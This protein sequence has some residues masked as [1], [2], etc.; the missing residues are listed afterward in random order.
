MDPRGSEMPETCRPP[1]V[2]ASSHA[3]VSVCGEGEGGT[4]CALVWGISWLLGAEPGGGRGNT[5]GPQLISFR[6]RSQGL[7]P[8][9][10]T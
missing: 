2:A 9:V 3:L 1:G 7:Q 10:S 8:L 4:S 6:L 5:K